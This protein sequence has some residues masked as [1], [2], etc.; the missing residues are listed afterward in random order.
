MTVL[1][2][3]HVEESFFRN[4]KEHISLSYDVASELEI[5]NDVYKIDKLLTVHIFSNAR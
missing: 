4:L 2:C 1:V 3:K 5:R